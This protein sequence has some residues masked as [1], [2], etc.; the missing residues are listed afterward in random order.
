MKEQEI[1]EQGNNDA[2]EII[3]AIDLPMAPRGGGG[4]KGSK[5]LPAKVTE[6]IAKCQV[7]NGFI[8]PALAGVKPEDQI[9]PLRGALRVFYAE[10]KNADGEVTHRGKNL[11]DGEAGKRFSLALKDGKI[12]VRRDS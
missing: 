4:A 6:A 2:L 8:A 3:N 7:G 12:L 10:V 11:A 9:G 5:Y 1:P